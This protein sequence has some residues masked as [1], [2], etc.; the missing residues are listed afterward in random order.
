VPAAVSL[1]GVLP[2]LGAGPAGVGL[3]V[4]LMPVIGE[5]VRHLLYGAALGTTYPVL[6]LARRPAA[7][8]APLPVVLPAS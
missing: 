7:V 8:H 1:L 4:G 2:L 5:L 3:G 6:L